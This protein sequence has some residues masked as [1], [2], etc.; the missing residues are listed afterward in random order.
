LIRRRQSRWIKSSKT[1]PA[2]LQNLSPDLATI[3]SHNIKRFNDLTQAMP[4][5]DQDAIVLVA[6]AL[7]FLRNGGID[8]LEFE[9]VSS[10]KLGFSIP[11]DWNGQHPECRV[12]SI[13]TDENGIESI[14]SADSINTEPQFWGVTMQRDDQT[15][16]WVKDCE[17]KQEAQDLTNLLALIDVAAEQNEHEKAAKLA[18]IHENRI[19]NDPISTEVSISGAK[20]EQNDDN[21]RQY[22]IV[23]YRDKDL[24]KAAGARWDKKA[25]AWYVGSEADIQTLQ[26]WLPENVSRQQEP[27]IDPHVNLL[28]CCAL[29][30]V[31][32][33]AIIR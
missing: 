21:A 18:N 8:N 10:D 1:P 6:D 12:M 30:V 3:A 7:K 17:S 19:R 4:K 20:T 15:F 28:T 29:K 26:R 23:P 32:L 25:R 24:A 14:V 31:W 2:Y 27:A 9:E 5:K 22:L 13:Q 33:M 11:A 16:Q